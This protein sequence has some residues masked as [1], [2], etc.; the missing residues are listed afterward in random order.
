MDRIDIWLPVEHIDYEK[1]SGLNSADHSAECSSDIKSRVLSAREL[2]KLR[3]G[4][5]MKLNAHMHPKDVERL[6][7]DPSARDVLHKSAEQLKLSPR[8]YHRMI[9]L[10]RTIADLDNADIIN[11]FHILEALQ[12]RPKQN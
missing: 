9:K 7:I 11:E 4:T 8:S 10:A 6:H 2:Q 12:Y 1:L 3:F 5:S